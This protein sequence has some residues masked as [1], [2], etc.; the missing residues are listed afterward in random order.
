VSAATA[1]VIAAAFGLIGVVVGGLLNLAA[2]VWQ[3]HRRDRLRARPVAR[4]VMRELGDMQGLL[5]AAAARGDDLQLPKPKEWKAGAEVLVSVVD[6]RTW[7]ALDEAY[8]L[9]R[10]FAPEGEPL[11]LRAAMGA[12]AP[13]THEISAAIRDAQQQLAPYAD[14]PHGRYIADSLPVPSD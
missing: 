1:A 3:E 8:T 7:G 12:R 13:H 6:G 9:A 11:P 2:A 4:L 10:Y 5:Y 14:L